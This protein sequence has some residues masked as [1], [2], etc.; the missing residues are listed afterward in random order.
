MMTGERMF[1]VYSRVSTK[2]RGA[3]IS[4]MITRYPDNEHNKAIIVGSNLIQAR[5]CQRLVR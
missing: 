1:E 5:W 3:M 4:P 2:E